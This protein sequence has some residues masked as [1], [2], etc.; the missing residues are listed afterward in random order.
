M[1]DETKGV[2]DRGEI[3]NKYYK[4]LL[5][6]PALMLLS[7]LIYLGMFYSQHGDIMRKD[8][9]LTGG[10]SLTIYSSNISESELES[11]LK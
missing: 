5:L 10:T 9:T 8:V 1:T 6:I 11:F 3:Y 4:L 2:S 7:S